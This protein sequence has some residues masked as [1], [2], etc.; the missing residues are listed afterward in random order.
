[1]G[2]PIARLN[3]KISKKS[4]H[5]FVRI[6]RNICFLYDENRWNRGATDLP[7]SFQTRRNLSKVSPSTTRELMKKGRFS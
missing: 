2:A 4:C 6:A 1:M 5:T 3:Q 7:G